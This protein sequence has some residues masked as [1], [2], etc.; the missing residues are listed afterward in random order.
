MSGKE[1]RQKILSAKP[2]THVRYHTGVN[3]KGCDPDTL[4]VVRRLYDEGRIELVQKRNGPFF[5]HMA[6]RRP[7][8]IKRLEEHTFGYYG[9][10][11][12]AR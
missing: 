3:T 6:I 1:I 5:D 11:S 9:F 7:N 4:A 2:W 12:W 10:S 8:P